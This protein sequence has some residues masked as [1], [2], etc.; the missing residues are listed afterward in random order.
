MAEGKLSP[1]IS[2][3]ENAEEVARAAASSFVELSRAAIDAQGRFSVA[4]SGGSTPKRAYQL[5]ASDEFKENVDWAKTHV[6]FGDERCVPPDDADSNYRMADE[7]LLS[8]VSIP[9]RNV[10]RIM[11]EGDAV[12]NS[13]L[14]E[15]ELQIF[16]DN[17]A[18]PRF[19]LMLLGMGDD[20]HTASLFPETEALAEMRAW[21]V[22]NWIEKLGAYR[23]TL[24]APAINRSA[25][26]AFLVTGASKAARL[27]EIIRGPREP[28]RLP[29]QLIRA[30][31]GT[32][33]WFVD[34]A[35]A[36]NL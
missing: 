30:E 5:L 24:S 22:A 26:I 8:R 16:F 31:S 13:R 28:E 33:A 32:L 20:G 18:W 25:H 12:A 35:A 27:K 23:I 9:S 36:A 3:F 17:A 34:K 19:D 14:Y 7:A 4:L 6:F 1:E 15:D 29:S 21:V 11:G 10:H 2:V